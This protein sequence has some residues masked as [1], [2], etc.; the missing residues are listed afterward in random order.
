MKQT[1]LLSALLI[2][3]LSA[4][5]G[6]VFSRRPQVTL[7]VPETASASRITEPVTVSDSIAYSLLFRLLST[8]QPENQT[9]LR[10]YIGRIGFQTPADTETLLAVA[11]DFR[12]AVADID[13]QAR[14]MKK[15][16]SLAPSSTSET[17]AAA[18]AQLR[19]RYHAIIQDS[20]NSVFTRL[21]E[22][23]R[24]KLR[25]FMDSSFKQKVKLQS[26]S[27]AAL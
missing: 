16:P 18:R 24:V 8:P 2:I 9:H 22:D 5:S 4:I 12:K 15:D 21:S 19:S 26:D 1:I 6:F 27:G 11:A 14:A 13:E 20:I 7:P 10:G 17:E 3:G 23:G 25:Q